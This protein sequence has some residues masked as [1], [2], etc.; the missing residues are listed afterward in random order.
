MGA[1]MARRLASA[2]LE[3]RVWNRTRA[4]AEALGDDVAMVA[5]TAAEA[6]AGA[7]AV[8]TMLSDA[9][10]VEAAMDGP[11]G[12]LVGAGADAIWLQSSTVGIAGTERLAALA[13]EH[14][15]TFVDAPVIGTK[16]PAE[17]GKLTIVGSGPDEVRAQLE[18]V[19]AAIGDR[20]LWLGEAGAGSR[21]KLVANAWLVALTAGL[22]ETIALAERLGVDPGDFLDVIKGG[23][24]GPPYAELKGRAMIARDLGEAAFPLKHAEKDARLVLEALDGA[25]LELLRAAREDFRRALEAGHGDED[26]GAVYRAHGQSG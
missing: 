21:M 17:Q 19:F 12:G 11:D 7:D 10:A 6:T 8:L 15:V 16:Q 23:P 25:D 13:G 1:A 22:G 20:T 24:I 18:P 4:R 26:M 5:A 9:G 2:G 3:V 14:G